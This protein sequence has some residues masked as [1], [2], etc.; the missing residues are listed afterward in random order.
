VPMT[1]EYLTLYQFT[2][3]LLG[4]VLGS[5]CYGLG[6]RSGKWRRRICGSF[7]LAFTVNYVSFL[8]GVWEWPLVFVWL[9]LYGAF[10]IGYGGDSIGVKLRKRTL[11][12]LAVCTAGTLFWPIFGPKMLWITIPHLYIGLWSVYFGVR[13]PIPAAAEEMLICALLNI[14]LISYP[15]LG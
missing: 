10:S 15:F 8:R 5:F 11:Y 4:L 1:N 12:A 3:A 6:G 9:F 2:C 14:G 13:N 7:V